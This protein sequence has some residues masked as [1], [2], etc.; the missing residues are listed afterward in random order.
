MLEGVWPKE[1]SAAPA[2]T[3]L[4]IAA[5]AMAGGVWPKVACAAP[6]RNYSIAACAIPGGVWP[7]VACTVL[8]LDASVQ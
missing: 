6:G 7:V 5:C 4:L 8:H 3:Y 2:W 1:A